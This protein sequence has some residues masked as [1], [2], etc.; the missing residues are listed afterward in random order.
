ML[1]GKWEGIDFQTQMAAAKKLEA[2]PPLYLTVPPFYFL[3]PI[4]K[5]FFF[6]FSGLILQLKEPPSSGALLKNLEVNKG[7]AKRNSSLSQPAIERCS[8]SL[9]GPH[10]DINLC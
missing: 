1:I 7:Y 9:I 6:P 5:I 8:C 3:F 4:S 2:R 10:F